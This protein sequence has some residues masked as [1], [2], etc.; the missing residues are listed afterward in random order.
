[1]NLLLLGSGGREHAFAW[2]IAQSLKCTKL[3]IAPGNAGT[4]LVGEN[5]DLAIDDF[6][7]IGKF[8]IEKEIQ[9]VIPASELPLV[10]GI[11][12]FFKASPELQ[13][14]MVFGPNQSGALLEGSKA[15]AK[16]FMSRHAIPTAAYQEFDK[17][18]IEKGIAYLRQHAMPVVLKAD[19]LAA[20]KGVLICPT[21][22][23]A[24]MGFKQMLEGNQFGEAGHRVVVES[25][26]KG[27]ELSVFVLTDGTDYCLLPT[28]KDY[29]RIGEGDTG[30]NTG[31]MGAVS[32]VPFVND[33]LMSKIEAKIIQ[34][35]IHGL[36]KDGINYQGFI[37]FGLIKVDEEPWVIEYNCRMGDPETEAVI[38]LI[39]NDLIDLFQA[40][41]EKR[42]K[43]VQIVCSKQVAVTIV[44][45][46]GGYPE[47]FEK[48]KPIK[49]LLNDKNCIIFQAGTKQAEGRTVSNGGRVVM[50]T[51]IGATLQEALDRSKERAE[52]IQFENKYY[53]S[54]IGFDLG[55][56]K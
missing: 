19:G 52:A 55:G 20:G 24:V 27:I 38:P 43:G 17:S 39:E 49:G 15:H 25:F 36:Q 42:L 37:Y 3:Y 46:S 31:G 30:L 22:E 35:T 8:C 14:L 45:A 21:V 26:L 13:H 9:L 5:V 51:G 1:M 47:S 2:K 50:V 54:D 53:R 4:A 29:K 6:K 44:L 28:A 10:K 18:S 40:T 32:P 48:N 12:D 33:I 34:P 23:E 56:N 16:S 41:V 7:A 11:V